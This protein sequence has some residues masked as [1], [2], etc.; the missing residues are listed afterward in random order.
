MLANNQT[1]TVNLGCGQLQMQGNTKHVHSMPN[2]ILLIDDDASVR[3]SFSV[4]LSDSGYRVHEAVNGAEGVALAQ[5]LKPDLVLCDLRMP[6]MDGLDVIQHLSS[7]GLNIPVIVISGLGEIADVVQALRL[8]AADYLTKPIENLEVLEYSINRSIKQA[9]LIAEN[10]NYS[11]QLESTNSQ[12][13]RSLDLL[14]MDQQAGR[15]VQTRLLPETPFV[16]KNFICRHKIVPSLYLSGDFVDYWE[17]D[18]GQLVFYIA[19]VSGHGASSAFVTVLL[20]YMARDSSRRFYRERGE[21]RASDILETLNTE[22]TVAN[23]QKHVTMFLGI[24]D[25]SSKKLSYS[26]AG[27]YPMPIVGTTEGYELLEEKSFPIG[28]Q[29]GALYTEHEMGIGDSFT[30]NLFSDGV[31]ELFNIDNL[32]GKEARLVDVVSKSHGKFENVSGRLDLDSVA[33]A[34]DDVALLTIELN[35]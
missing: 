35:Q 2:Q 20:K 6:D 32:D 17:T 3:R 28:V 21:L 18:G 12:L 5:Q 24:I 4:F 22:L 7:E 14:R 27:H 11:K 26:A 15:V 31:L 29:K 8:G 30:I 1:Q 33:N 13:R 23:L 19:D 9:A 10:A 34:P 25:S 16:F